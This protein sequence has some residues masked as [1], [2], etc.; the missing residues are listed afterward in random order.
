MQASCRVK[1]LSCVPV[2]N[3]LKP[4]DEYEL[5]IVLFIGKRKVKIT[6]AEQLHQ[7]IGDQ[8][9]CFSPVLPADVYLLLLRVLFKND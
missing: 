7:S 1:N 8:G 6:M 9:K 5:V 3:E 4:R 2:V